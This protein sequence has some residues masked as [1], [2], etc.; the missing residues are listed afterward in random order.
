LQPFLLTY[1]RLIKVYDVLSSQQQI[2]C[3]FV[4]NY[5][6]SMSLSG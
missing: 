6:V 4:I 5:P 3:K 1:P 2:H